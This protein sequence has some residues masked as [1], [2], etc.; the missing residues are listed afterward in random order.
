MFHSPYANCHKCCLFVVSFHSFRYAI[1][2]TEILGDSQFVL[3]PPDTGT[4][5]HLL[6]QTSVQGFL[7]RA[8]VASINLDTRWQLCVVTPLFF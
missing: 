3:S 5:G 7:P 4:S 6:V 1:S 2:Y 8:N